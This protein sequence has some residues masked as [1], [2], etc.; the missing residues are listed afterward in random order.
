[1]VG[2]AGHYRVRRPRAPLWSKIVIIVGLVLML[3][4]LGL[5]AGEKALVARYTSALHP[6][7]LLAPGARDG[8]RTAL[9]GPLNYLL[10]GS[11]A[12]A[13]NPGMG[14]RSDT[15]IIVH[16]P[17]TLD[18]A[19]LISIPRDLRVD[20]PPMLDRGF[21]GAQDKINASFQ[22]GGQGTGGVQLLSATLT[23]LIGVHFDGAAVVDFSGF[24]K[25]VKDLGGVH[26]CI[27]ERV[28]SIHTGHVF[29]PGCQDLTA[30]Q[31]LDYLRQRETL[32]GGDFDRQ[33]H[34]QQFLQAI[35]AKLFA[36]GVTSNPF[37]LDKVIRDIGSA[38]SVD[39][40]GVPLDQLAFTLR[41]VQPSALVGVR[42]PST[43]QTI[44][45]V[46]YVLRKP[47]ATG[48]FTAIDQDTLDTWVAQNPRWVNQ[49]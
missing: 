24:D 18:R 27:D 28:R 33:R 45:G 17:A 16:I 21:T 32:P 6:D 5:I 48:L 42:L 30:T 2:A 9:R 14:A 29:E 3:A 46:S 31:T 43:T 44:G 10:I 13:S 26:L 35:F 19:Y 38:V 39:L 25:I 47:D 36:S 4:S 12:R 34:Q 20:I 1:M 23:Q 7:T 15:I 40:N 41:N 49:L 37:K 8:S 11:D 22:D